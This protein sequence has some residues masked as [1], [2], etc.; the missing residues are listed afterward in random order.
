MA[1][2]MQMLMN[3]RTADMPRE[4]ELRICELIPQTMAMIKID[5]MHEKNRQHPNTVEKKAPNVKIYQLFDDPKYTGKWLR[6]PNY[7]NFAH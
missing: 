1:D 3:G 7:S 4:F 6:D 2:Y 5:Q